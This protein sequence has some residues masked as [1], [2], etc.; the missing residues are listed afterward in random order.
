M[1]VMSWGRAIFLY[2][3]YVLIIYY[4]CLVYGM[5]TKHHTIHHKKSVSKSRRSMRWLFCVR[6]DGLLRCA[7]DFEAK[8][9]TDIF[10]YVQNIPISTR[11]HGRS[12]CRKRCLGDLL[13]RCFLDWLMSCRAG[14]KL[15]RTSLRG[16][17]CHIGPS[18]MLSRHYTGAKSGKI[19]DIIVIFHEFWL[20]P[21][22]TNLNFY[23]VGFEPLRHFLP[24]TAGQLQ[25]SLFQPEEL[26]SWT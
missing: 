15:F 10:F 2:C 13:L 1:S 24:N 17:Q 5:V 8:K 3:F 6:T 16:L 9:I 21:K 25:Q 19:T 12:L 4:T 26:S 11:I 14:L 18:S 20:V 23:V 22:G 7:G